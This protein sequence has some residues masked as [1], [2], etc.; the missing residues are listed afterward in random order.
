MRRPQLRRIESLE[1]RLAPAGVVTFTDVDGDLVTVRTNLG[2]NESLAAALRLVP[3]GGSGG[4][5]LAQVL[6]NDPVFAGTRLRITAQPGTGGDG[7]VNVGELVANGLDLGAVTVGG[8][9]GLVYAGDA[10]VDTPGI[11]SLVAGSIGRFGTDPVSVVG[12]SLPILRVSGHL[13][14]SFMVL[15]RAG[16]VEIGGSIDGTL[17]QVFFGASSIGRMVV[18]GSLRGGSENGSGAVESTGGIDEVMIGGSLEGG[19]GL[20]SGYVRGSSLGTVRIGG[21]IIGGIGQASGSVFADQ[22]ITRVEVGSTLE[23]GVLGGKGEQSGFIG[24]EGAIGSIIVSGSVT[25]SS[26]I[27]SGHLAGLRIDSIDVG[28]ELVGGLGL[29]SGS[30]RAVGRLGALRVKSIFAGTGRESGSVRGR[31]LGDIT[32]R[33]DIVGTATRPVMIM[34]L[35]SLSATGARAIDS[36]TVGGTMSRALVLGGWQDGTPQNGAA[37]I[38]SVT[39]QGTMRASSIVAGVQPA[40]FPQFGRET[41]T[42]IPGAG[43]SRIESVVVNGAARGN[44]N[45]AESFGVVAS[46]I[47]VVRL[48]G[49]SYTATTAGIRPAGDNFKVRLV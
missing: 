3:T 28:G 49:R 30:V 36:L 4:F 14:R 25:G 37:R 10:N 32:V 16:D 47:G 31:L 5:Q 19:E 29:Q 20:F 39:V 12:G 1:S 23:N 26:G 33:R 13:E 8:D 45:K 17:R 44:T 21:S 43:G 7:Q 34:G 6:F 9:L 42:P 46:S 27:R 24:S 38:G 11:A 40:V 15:G 18:G 41:D 22:G 48:G 2:T 35:G